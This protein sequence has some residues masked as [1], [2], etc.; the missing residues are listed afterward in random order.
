MRT[1]KCFKHCLAW[2]KLWEQSGEETSCCEETSRILFTALKRKLVPCITLG[3]AE[4]RSIKPCCLSHYNWRSI[5]KKNVCLIDQR[6]KCFLAFDFFCL[7]LG[8]PMTNFGPPSSDTFTHTIIT[9]V[10]SIFDREPRNEFGFTSPVKH[11]VG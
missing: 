10:Y 3:G 4:R 5:A 9:V 11:Q 2:F 6:S 1:W 8:F 7:L